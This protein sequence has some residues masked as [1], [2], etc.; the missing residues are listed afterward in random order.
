MTTYEIPKK[1]FFRMNHV[2]P[3]YKN[4]YENTLIFLTS[5]ISNLDEMEKKQFDQ[6][7]DEAISHYKTNSSSKE[8]THQNWRT[9]ISALFGL[10]EYNDGNV[11][12]SRMSKMLAEHQDMAEFFKYFLYSFQY[13]G[14]HVREDT[15]YNMISNG[16]R[17]KPAQYIISVMHYAENNNKTGK[18][19]Y[20]TK[21]EAC[22]CILNDLRCTRD[23]EAPEKVWKRITNNRD[24]QLKYDEK[25]D[26]IRYAGDIL[27]YMEKANLLVCYD[28]KHFY[29]NINR[30]KKAIEDFCRSQEWFDGYDNLYVL[31][32][33][34]KKKN[35]K[36]RL[37]EYYKM[38][39]EQRN[40][41]FSYTN[42]DYPNIDFRTKLSAIVP[43]GSAAYI[44][45]KKKEIE[46]LYKELRDKNIIKTKDTGDF[47]EDRIYIYECERVEQNRKDILHIIK[48]IPTAFAVGYDLQ[49]VETDESVRYKKRYIEVKTTITEE[50]LK[51]LNFAFHMT[52]N[53][54]STAETVGDR[55]FIY[56]LI[57]NKNDGKSKLYIIQNPIDLFEHGLIT[58]VH[59]NGATVSFDPNNKKVCH[60]EEL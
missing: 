27:D 42:K 43:Q 34:D 47:G 45:A 4:D 41:W 35:D 1:H 53:E 37:K 14:G 50:K 36:K 58:M 2:R 49:S 57:V 11:R 29:L 7:M 20:I 15:V 54:I 13:P 30:E 52:P 31:I 48:P 16:I 21:A 17:F 12:A 26:I 38:I 28:H 3:R 23:N 59:N 46:K 44:E 24:K 9:E 19:P 10:L 8:K 51:T 40:A 6:K 32:A 22:H 5:S 60:C 25:S 56:R 39:R 18:R 55:Y 33:H